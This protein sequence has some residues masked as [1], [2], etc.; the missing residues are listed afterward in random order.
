MDKLLSIGK[1]I[2]FHG[3]QG[4][5]KVGYT[6]GAEQIFTELNE[7][8]ATKDSKKV[9]L[10]PEKVRFHKKFAIIKFKEINSIDEV[11][12]LKGAYLKAPKSKIQGFLKENEFY[13]DDLVGSSAF[14]LEGNN[15][16]KI[17][18]VSIAKGQ[19]LLFIKDAQ[20]KE[21]IIPFVK[22]IVTEVNLKEEK[23]IIKKI[24]GLLEAK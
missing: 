6:E 22:E 21:H 23:V 2:N 14:D 17:S 9:S 10:T 18:G 1:I 3:V 13:I 7:I 8:Y 5:V 15:I 16:G 12:A 20:D 19:D 24:E 4:E 11:I